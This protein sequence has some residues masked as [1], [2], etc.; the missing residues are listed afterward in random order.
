MSLLQV[1]MHNS[2][3]E[4]CNLYS[5]KEPV[6]Q[7]SLERSKTWLKATVKPPTWASGCYRSLSGHPPNET[8]PKQPSDLKHV[9]AV[10]DPKQ[11]P[12]LLASWHEERLHHLGVNFP[13]ERACF[14]YGQARSGQISLWRTNINCGLFL[15]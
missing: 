5:V 14:L 15:F 1:S 13:Q 7:F 8:E 10:R 11:R 12:H 6:Q 4:Y 2:F 3:L 9:S